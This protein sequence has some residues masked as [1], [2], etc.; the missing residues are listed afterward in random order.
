M[1][2]DLDLGNNIYL[3]FEYRFF[4]LFIFSFNFYF[5]FLCLDE[6]HT[7]NECNEHI[8]I[9]HKDHESILAFCLNNSTSTKI[10]FANPREIQELDISL[11]LESPNWYED[12][13]D[14]DMLNI[15]K[16]NES[17]SN[18]GFLLIQNAEQ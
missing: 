3:F 5:F 9:I 18:S 13:C 12:E 11:L 15:T 8:R 1:K 4:N 6:N 16:E 14:Y 17:T 2:K 10:A 7:T